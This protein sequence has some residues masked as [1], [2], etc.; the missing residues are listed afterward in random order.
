MILSI[1]H[2]PDSRL[3][4][5]AKKVKTVDDAIKTLVKNMFDTM[6]NQEGIGL[7][8]TQVNQHFQV[9]VMDVPDSQSDY[10]QILE[11]RKN[12]THK[13]RIKYPLCLINPK[14]IE[15]NG[16]KKNTEGCLS[17]PGFKA[18]VERFNHIVVESLNAKGEA[19]TLQ[20]D[21]LLAICIQHEIDHLNGILFIDH[22]SKLEQKRLDQPSADN[23]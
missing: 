9:L 5:V 17:I 14:I 10:E 1:L 4:T 3:R 16:C 8:A 11:N 13:E 19:L 2:Y 18:E 23:H 12:N 20:A 15:K 6:Y 22:L 21:G 7:A